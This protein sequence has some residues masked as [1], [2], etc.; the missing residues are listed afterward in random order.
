MRRFLK[1]GASA[2]FLSALALAET[3]NGTLVDASC[4]S[5]QKSAACNPTASTT[6]FAIQVSD[7]T[8]YNLDADGNKKA[9]QALNDSNSSA[10]RAKD[11]NASTSRVMATVNGTLT[12]STIK[13]DSIEV[14]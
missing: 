11:P 12:G 5:Q 7:G 8:T 3:Y 14:H 4:A 6:A 9:A 2:L 10:D 13:V 1:L